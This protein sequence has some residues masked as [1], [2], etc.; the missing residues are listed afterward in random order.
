MAIPTPISFWNFDESSGNAVDALGVNTLTNNNTATFVTGLIG[1]AADLES[2][3]SQSFS[4]A[5]A[6]QTGLDFSGDC[7]F[8]GWVNLESL[9]STNVLFAKTN[10]NGQ[11]AYIIRLTDD[12]GTSK[13]NV[14]CFAGGTTANRRT[15]TTNS[16]VVSSTGVWTHLVATFDI[17]TGVWV[18]YKDGSSVAVTTNNAG[19]VASIYD[20][21]SDFQ[22]GAANYLGTPEQFMDGKI[23]MFGVWNVTLSSTDASDLYNAGAGIQYPFVPATSIKTVDDLAKASVK[24]VDQLAIASVKTIN[25]LA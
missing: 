15:A 14:E 16:A 11:R 25:G 23:D 7:S 2:G 5:D 21:A 1:N 6:S 3:S 9:G 8:A 18:I 4:I 10:G 19:T 22:V 12:G 17:D 13:L 24:T 20:T